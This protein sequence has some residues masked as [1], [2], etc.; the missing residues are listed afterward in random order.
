[1]TLEEVVLQPYQ[2]SCNNKGIRGK[3]KKRSETEISKGRKALETAQ[4][5]NNLPKVN[6][7]YDTSINPPYWA[8]SARFVKQIGKLKFY[9]E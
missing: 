9:K 3:M 4:G 5:S 2:F 6:L 1:M 7:Y 8:S